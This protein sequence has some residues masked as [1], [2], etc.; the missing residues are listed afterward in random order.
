MAKKAESLDCVEVKRR[1]QRSLARSLV[2][3]TPDEQVETL[4][5]LA[6][7]TPLWRSLTKR[8]NDR[9]R[10]AAGARG[11]RRSAG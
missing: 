5:R 7:K 1:A 9:P 11:Q 6:R 10:K 2:G 4:R 8:E 3:K